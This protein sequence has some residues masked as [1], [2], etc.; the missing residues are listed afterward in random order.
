MTFATDITRSDSEKRSSRCRGLWRPCHEKKLSGLLR[1]SEWCRWRDM[2]GYGGVWRAVVV[3]ASGSSGVAFRCSI[4]VVGLPSQM[5]FLRSRF[6]LV[7]DACLAFAEHP[8]RRVLIAKIPTVRTS[9]FPASCSP[10]LLS[11]YFSI[12][13]S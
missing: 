10:P 8:A 7:P 3:V 1:F 11:L 13:V 5:S 9:L 4:T 12:V 2:A 6:G